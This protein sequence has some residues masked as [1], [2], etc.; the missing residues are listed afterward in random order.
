MFS[1]LLIELSLAFSD[2]NN[3]FTPQLTH[4]FLPY[5]RGH[6]QDILYF[7]TTDIIRTGYVSLLLAQGFKKADIFL[8]HVLMQSHGCGVKSC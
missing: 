5:G 1:G 3:V 2:S 7:I 8:C 6:K 4:S